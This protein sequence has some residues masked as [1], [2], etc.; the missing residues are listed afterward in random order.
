MVSS[1]TT[2]SFPCKLHR[3]Q[4]SRIFFVIVIALGFWH[5]LVLSP[6]RWCNIF[7]KQFPF[8]TWFLLMWNVKICQQIL[9]RII[10]IFN[11]WIFIG[12]DYFHSVLWRSLLD[13]M[14]G[15]L[16]VKSPIPVIPQ[17]YSWW[18]GLTWKV[19]SSSSL[20]SNWPITHKLLLV[21][22]SVI[23]C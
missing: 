5:I 12:V 6:F 7:F 4:Y 10:I 16:P 22:N 18:P 21:V 20:V 1:I 8:L 17:K 19:E 2:D 14:S 23:L 9:P 15:V 13:D 11:G 3:V